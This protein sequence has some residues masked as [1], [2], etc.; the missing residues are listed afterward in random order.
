MRHHAGI[1][2]ISHMGQ[3]LVAGSAAEGAL[4]ALLTN[5]IAR[6]APGE[7]HYTLLL[8]E[9]GGVIDDLIA[10]RLADERF[11]LIVNASMI[12]AD[13]AWMAP[14]L[15]EAGAGFEN[16]SACCAAVAVQ[17]PEAPAIFARMGPAAE[18]PPRNGV[19]TFDSPGGTAYVC[20]TGYTGEDGFELVCPVADA[21]EWWRRA[22][23]AGATPCGLG[24]RDSLR[25]EM[26]YPLN[27]SDLSPDRSPLE[28]GLGYFVDLKKDAFMG[29]DALVRQK[30]EGLPSKLCALRMLE[31]GP[32]PAPALPR[33]RRRSPDWRTLQRRPLAEP[34]H[35]NRHGLPAGRLFRD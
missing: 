18:L 34:W 6:L 22:L 27:G 16:I 21:G 13:A 17:G 8:N 11:L 35:R 28:A 5:D 23:G 33:A 14:H 24:A 31:Q 7:A 20:R 12:D 4:N 9:R 15:A 1:F 25:L 2:D 3:F 10:Y 32:T 26:G 30:A 29:R 19:A